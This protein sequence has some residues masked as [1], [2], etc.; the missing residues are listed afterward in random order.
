MHPIDLFLSS[1]GDGTFVKTGVKIE[2]ITSSFLQ[3]GGSSAQRQMKRNHIPIGRM[4]LGGQERGTSPATAVGQRN[5]R[6]QA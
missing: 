1:R 3:D 2:F 5:S 6:I 4:F